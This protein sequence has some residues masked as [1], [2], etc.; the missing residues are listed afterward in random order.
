MAATAYVRDVVTA[1][2]RAS[3]LTRKLLAYS[4][5]AAFSLA[6]IDVAQLVRECVRLLAS[7]ISPRATVEIALGDQ[8]R[9]KADAT[10]LR[11]IVINLLTNASDALGG[12]E[13]TIRISSRSV[14]LA[15]SRDVFAPTGQ[16]LDAGKYV[17][18][19]IEDTGV[20]MDETTLRRVF[21]P[22]FT[23]KGQGHGL[24][25]SAVLGIVRAHHGAVN[26]TSRPG[27]GSAFQLYFP[28]SDATPETVQDG[29][30]KPSL[31]DR[32]LRVLV[33]DDDDSV[34]TLV[35]RA[36]ELEGHEPTPVAAAQAALDKLA[37]TPDGWDV[38]LMDLTMPRMSGLEALSRIRERSATLPVI[39]MSGYNSEGVAVPT[40]DPATSFL[41]KPFRVTNLLHALDR[42]VKRD[43]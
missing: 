1:A 31:P 28:A 33:V 40:D 26:V 24:G 14:E 21:D 27:Q 29:A 2:Q 8:L 25:L 19:E 23:T 9:A 34:R 13:G 22:F 16:A 41:E 5:K 30:M 38:V 18:L 17:L 3:E 37:A 10:Q 20:G 15:A 35:H 6:S 39:I 42:A 43:G 7:V 36:L 4:G 12:K 11:Q 32:A